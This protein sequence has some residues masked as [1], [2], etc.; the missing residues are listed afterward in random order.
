MPP[1]VRMTRLFLSA[2]SFSKVRVS[3]N[4]RKKERI[5]RRGGDGVGDRHMVAVKLAPAPGAG[6]LRAE[7]ER[8]TGPELRGVDDE[9]RLR[10]QVV[11]R[12]S[13]EQQVV[14]SRFE[15]R[16]PAGKA[17]QR[18]PDLEPL[19]MGRKRPRRDQARDLDQAS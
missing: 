19:E 2:P 11:Q 16:R 15:Q 3:S 18:R 14:E 10:R 12:R 1:S 17:M 7:A 13:L 6:L 4:A 9:M 8:R 5:S